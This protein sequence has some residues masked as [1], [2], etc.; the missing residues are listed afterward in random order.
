[1][2]N[3]NM[4]Q[5]KIWFIDVIRT[6]E[7][8]WVMSSMA[9][10]AVSILT[11]I[12]WWKFNLVFLKYIAWVLGFLSILLFILFIILFSI[13]IFKF[14]KEVKKDLQHPIVSNFF[15]WIFISA[16]VIVSVIWNVLNPLWWCLFPEFSSKVFYLIALILGT[17]IP[18]LV[19]FILTISEKVELKH[20]IWI[21]FLPPVGIFVLIFAWNFMV[22]HN[23]W[24]NFIPYINILYFGIAFTLY[25]L[26]LNLIYSRFKFH[27][28]P[29]PEVAPSFVIWLAPI[30]V[31]IIALNT[32]VKVIEKHNIFNWDPNFIANIVKFFSPM[33]LW[34]WIWWFLVT[35]LILTYYLLKKTIPYTLGWWAFVF[36]MAAFGIGIKFVSINIS[37]AWLCSLV[38]FIWI[39]AF[40][41]W[42][43]VFYKT[44]MWIITKK[45]F[46]RPKL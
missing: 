11:M 31:S 45:A 36:P 6:M 4:E 3:K 13:R 34:F 21:W 28:L 16:A 1:M 42:I 26:V 37:C 5:E 9:T 32:F 7:P 39:L 23:I 38:V 27:T 29:Q 25:F 18:I 24:S 14:P 15:A 20:A 10:W 46:I 30:W 2:T 17:I 44:L 8:R 12:V 19:P 35:L 22:L 43:Y 41:L 33:I 40:I